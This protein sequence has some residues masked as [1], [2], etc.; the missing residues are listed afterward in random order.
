M[1]KFKINIADA[2][3]KI[4]FLKEDILLDG[5]FH[6]FATKNKPNKRNGSYVAIFEEYRKYCI[7][8]DF[9]DNE[10][11]KVFPEHNN[12]TID[13]NALQE[14]EN[15]KI[16]LE[17]Q[18]QK[19]YEKTSVKAT[20]L[21]KN[22]NLFGTSNYLNYKKCKPYNIK[23]EKGFIAIP[24]YDITGK[25]WGLQKI[26]D[27][28]NNKNLKLFDSG[29]NQKG[30]FG[31][32]G[33]EPSEL[34]NYKT[35]YVAE[36]YSTANSIYQAMNIPV[37]VAFY[38]HN[39]EPTIS[40]LNEVLSCNFIICADNDQFKFENAGI[41]CAK[42]TCEK[43]NNCIYIFPK[44]K[45]LSSEPT[46][47]NDLHCLEGLEEVKKQLCT[48]KNE[49][50]DDCFL[51]N[52]NF[53]LS[54]IED[55]IYASFYE[56]EKHLMSKYC[57]KDTPKILLNPPKH[58]CKILDCIYGFAMYP[59]PILYTVNLIIAIGMMLG[60]RVQGRGLRTNVYGVSLL[61]SGWGKDGSLKAIEE[62]FS[63][64][65]YDENLI[66]GS[67]SDSAIFQK[68]DETKGLTLLHADEFGDFLTKIKNQNSNSEK[69]IPTLLTKLY[70]S[71]SS[72]SFKEEAKKTDPKKIKINQP[73]FAL[74]GCTNQTTLYEAVKSKD[75]MDGF[76]N[77]FI[78]VEGCLHK[79]KLNEMTFEVN[80]DVLTYF[81]EIINMPTNSNVNDGDIAIDMT[82][83]TPEELIN[84]TTIKEEVGA[85]IM[86]S[87]YEEYCNKKAFFYSHSSETKE[88]AKGSTCCR[89]WEKAYRIAMILSIS[90]PK[91]SNI[92]MTVEAVRYAIA[93]VHY[94]DM[95]IF[96]MIDNHIADTL[97]E[98]K[99]LKLRWFIKTSCERNEG[100]SINHIDIMKYAMQSSKKEVEDTLN[101]LI[102][103]GFILK[104]INEGSQVSYK[105]IGE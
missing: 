18:L 62:I 95:F 94:S 102:S 91:D 15:S 104:E 64:L 4:G 2:I 37:I 89:S 60:H 71:A 105:Y 23:F 92:Y 69:R 63:Q 93:L 35:L 28:E 24:V 90:N 48:E 46:D 82:K 20:E 67:F 87:K 72:K 47:F 8:R 14:I 49:S 83:E 34:K 80:K 21:Y 17:Q 97:S 61:E 6:R 11:I 79:N 74:Y 78:F 86:L 41:K 30:N 81:N 59:Q 44:F 57:N 26:F 73:L 40:K 7:I 58:I 29:L 99:N 16:I 66:S 32:I 50:L 3:S 77:R 103:A 10:V 52:K 45:D 88:K 31:I 9:R 19:K 54:D 98:A 27:K 76:L 53:K 65:G 75:L 36:G 56:N 55:I 101:L 85:T 84:P 13:A 38:C 68:L 25:I 42:K 5:K 100:K 12:Y 33:C 22:L 43:H 70:T 39:I 51:K 1:E 96:D